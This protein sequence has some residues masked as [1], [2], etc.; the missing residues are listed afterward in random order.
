MI[1]ELRREFNASFT[2]R[3]YE[4][5][6][7]RL[8]DRVRTPIPFRIAETPLFI[9]REIQRQCEDA[10]IALALQV[11]D[12]AYIRASDAALDPRYTAANQTPRST[13]LT[14][15]F[16][17]AVDDAG[18]IAPRL[19][20]LQGFPSLMGF[21]LAFCELAQE[22]Y[23]LPSDLGYLNGG[24]SR[25]EFLAI[26]H[27]AIVADEDPESVVLMELDPWNQKTRADFAM[28][29]ELLGIGVADI[30]AVRKV[31]RSLEYQKDDRWIPI[32]RVYNRAIP[33]EIERRHVVLPFDW[34]DDLDVDWAGHPNWYF[35][36]SKFALPYLDHPTVPQTRFLSQI[37]SVPEDLERY[38][39]KPLYSF[40]GAGV[41]V[42]P[43]REQVMSIADE[44]KHQYVLQRRVDYADAVETPEG[45]TKAEVRMM[46]IWR[47]HEERPRPVIGLVRMGRGQLMGVD[48]NTSLRWI[49]AGCNFYEPDV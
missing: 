33:D 25:S 42:A 4:L 18:H 40:A 8:E 11:H 3:T 38:V 10:A 29:R 39:L 14:I 9:P 47:P 27:E 22:H 16:A 23:R 30:R 28:V 13:F 19:I 32:R 6:R 2:D 24:H 17:M 1:P 45:P 15:D 34:R 7:E 46:L 35:R 36:I 5:F 43:T 37:E 41:V 21:Q 44:Q 49:G 48:Q 20:E 26:L 31:G 12:P